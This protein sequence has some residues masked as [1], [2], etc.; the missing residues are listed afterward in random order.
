MKHATDIEHWALESMGKTHVDAKRERLKRLLAGLHRHPDSASLPA[1]S[2]QR[3]LVQS[4][5][6]QMMQ[7]AVHL[8]YEPPEKVLKEMG[9]HL[10]LE[11]GVGL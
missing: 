2:P 10:G 7:E 8:G 9:L 6:R 4:H 1:G 11:L 5:E 3:L